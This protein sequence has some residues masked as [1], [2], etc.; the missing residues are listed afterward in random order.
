MISKIASRAACLAEQTS[1]PKSFSN[2]PDLQ[3]GVPG[4]PKGRIRTK[5]APG[6]KNKYCFFAHI[7]LGMDAR[8]VARPQATAN[9]LIEVNDAALTSGGNRKHLKI[10]TLTELQ[11]VKLASGIARSAALDYLKSESEFSNF[12]LKR[13]V[14]FNRTEIPT[15]IS[16]RPAPT[17]VLPNDSK[18]WRLAQSESDKHRGDPLPPLNKIR[19]ERGSAICSFGAT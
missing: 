11:K 12:P 16:I 2:W 5:P 15:Y 18:V 1:N 14:D 13:F 17:K 4:L 7:A 6:K 3:G 8:M 9:M 10:S 19:S